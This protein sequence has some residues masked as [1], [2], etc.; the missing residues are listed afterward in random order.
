MIDKC[1]KTLLYSRF[2]RAT[3]FWKICIDSWLY[4]KKKKKMDYKQT[5]SIL[6]ANTVEVSLVITRIFLFLN[7][8]ETKKFSAESFLTSTDLQYL[9]SYFL[10]NRFLIKK[11]V[12]ILL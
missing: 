1:P 5:G 3:Q 6:I 12:Y 2:K 10:I 11:Y 9:V 8:S 7:F 4:V